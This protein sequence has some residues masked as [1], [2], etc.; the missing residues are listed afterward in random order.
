MEEYIEIALS[1]DVTFSLSANI[2]IPG[3]FGISAQVSHFLNAVSHAYQG[4]QIRAV[5]FGGVVGG[6]ACRY[7]V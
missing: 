5:F 3:P 6:G 2:N 7:S 1:V 4:G